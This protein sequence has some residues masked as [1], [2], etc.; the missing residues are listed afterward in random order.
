M[1][2]RESFARKQALRRYCV[3]AKKFE[4]YGFLNNHNTKIHLHKAI[5]RRTLKDYGVVGVT[6]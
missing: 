5:L 1:T 2:L 3:Q 4:S 6:V